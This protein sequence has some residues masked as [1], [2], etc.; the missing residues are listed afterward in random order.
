MPLVR[1]G[2]HWYGGSGK[3]ADN[4]RCEV[5]R[6]GRPSFRECREVP[7]MVPD[8]KHPVAHDDDGDGE[9]E[10]SSAPCYLRD[11]ETDAADAGG[12]GGAS[13]ADDADLPVPAG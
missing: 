7:I 10:C 4:E 9:V 3:V 11:F 2:T 12:A 13:D 1:P 8:R 5:L 6:R